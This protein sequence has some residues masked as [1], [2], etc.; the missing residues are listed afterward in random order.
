MDVLIF[1]IFLLLFIEFVFNIFFYQ[2]NAEK[3]SS[4]KHSKPCF[5]H[6]HALAD[7]KLLSAH[8][9]TF[10]RIY[11]IVS[12]VPCNTRSATLTERSTSNPFVSSKMPN[13]PN[14]HLEK[15]SFLL[16]EW[17]LPCCFTSSSI[18]WSGAWH[19]LWAAIAVL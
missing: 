5:A 13:L 10:S 6:S 8:F 18:S 2:N 14:K 7:F 9:P 15:H 12:G 1:F 3:K 4:K 19:S 11:T 16:L 17:P